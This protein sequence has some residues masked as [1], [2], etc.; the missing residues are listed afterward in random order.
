MVFTVNGGV[1]G[2]Y[3]ILSLLSIRRLVEKSQVSTWIRSKVN[4]AL[5]Q[6]I[7]LCFGGL[8]IATTRNKEHIDIELGSTYM[9]IMKKK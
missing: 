2:E 8:Y 5:P 9:W 7:M 1:A 4:L 6:S 3:K